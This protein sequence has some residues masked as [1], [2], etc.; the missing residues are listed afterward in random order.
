MIPFLRFVLLFLSFCFWATKISARPLI[1]STI[2]HLKIPSDKHFGAAWAP[3]GRLLVYNNRVHEKNILFIYD[4][5]TKKS[6]QIT[7]FQ[8]IFYPS[9]GPQGSIFA[10]VAD[11]KQLFSILKKKTPKKRIALKGKKFL[12]GVGDPTRRGISLWGF[13]KRVFLFRG[14]KPRYS[15]MA[16]RLMFSFGPFIYIWD[17]LKRRSE[18]LMFLTQGFSPRWAPDGRAI[19]FLKRP[20]E[21]RHGQV[22][23]GGIRIVDM[24][25]RAVEISQSGGEV[26]WSFDSH[27]LAYIDGA[28]LQKIPSLY[29]LNLKGKKAKP[30][31]LV[32]NARAPSFAPKLPYS[33]E[34]WIAF[35]DEKGVWIISLRTHR[36]YLVVAGGRTPRW[37]S[38]GHLLVRFKNA[39]KI[40]RIRTPN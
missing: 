7:Q 3:S 39:L 4:L 9:F 15:P 17:P 24:L 31:L 2:A 19:A 8:D 14:W 5:Q 11:Q 26:A 32:K 35:H 10:G 6:K 23:G 30:I 29:L 28:T 13:G 40:L 1:V 36:R 12:L 37:S 20:F 22:Q 27:Q 16:R 34:R 33:K 21:V 38:Q 25:F 18:G